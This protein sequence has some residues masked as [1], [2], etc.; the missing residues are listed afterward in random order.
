MPVCQS[1]R[2]RL[3]EVIEPCDN[4]YYPYRLC[5]G[6]HERLLARALRPLEYFNLAAKH[7][8]FCWLYD[9]FYDNDGSA[10]QP[11]IDVIVEKGLEFPLFDI[12]KED[13]EMLIDYSI[14]A[15][16]LTDDL[17]REFSKFDKE[18]IL[19]SLKQRLEENRRLSYR[20]YDLAARSL[21]SF[22]GDWIRSEWQYR[23]LD[24]LQ[25]YSECLAK[26]LPLAEG[27][28]YLTD[29]LDKFNSPSILSEK[30]KELIE[31]RSSL[32]LDWIEQNINRVVNIS[33]SWGYLA[34]ASQFD[35]ARAKKWLELGRPLSLVALDTLKNYS[36]TSETQNSTAWLRG[37]PQRLSN[38][39]TIENMNAVLFDYLNKDNVTRVR[40]AVNYI[41]ESWHRILKK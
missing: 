2:S 32:S 11:E 41:S 23:T 31:F 9:S 19:N 38:P 4:E 39:D 34:V 6:C 5:T 40:N 17:I 18:D 10:S 20:I 33:D 16:W 35:W 8:T 1:C 24:N 3:V 28:Y 12:I 25:D 14:V 36:V 21:G 13:L 29:E 30:L 15:W 37:N 26:C 27:F 22:A 7:G